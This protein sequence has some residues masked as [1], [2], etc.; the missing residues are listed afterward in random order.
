MVHESVQA[1][2]T[3]LPIL[4]RWLSR[5]I[6]SVCHRGLDLELYSR[7]SVVAAYYSRGSLLTRLDRPPQEPQS[8]SCPNASME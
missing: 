6:E 4:Q 5:R 3:T 1:F 2:R 7:T 8:R